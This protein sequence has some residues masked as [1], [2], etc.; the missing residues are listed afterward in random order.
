M[1]G[2]FGDWSVPSPSGYPELQPHTEL[3]AQGV[4]LG[5]RCPFAIRSCQLSSERHVTTEE[6]PS[7]NRT[8][9]QSG[10]EITPHIG[11]HAKMPRPDALREEEH[12]EDE[13]DEQRRE[14]LR[15]RF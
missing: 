1:G 15:H 4:T 7:D 14:E 8:T 10:G 9:D 11:A 6:R 13:D 5:I 12:S 2:C 3:D